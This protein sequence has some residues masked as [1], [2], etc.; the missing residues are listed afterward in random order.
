MNKLLSSLSVAVIAGAVCF[1]LC[2][3]VVVVFHGFASQGYIKSS[4][5]NQY[6]VSDSADGSFNFNDFGINFS[7]QLSPELRVG[8]QLFAQSRGNLGKDVVTVDWAYGDYRY[9]DWLGVRV[10]KVKI[11]LGLYNTSRDNDALR[12]PILLPRGGGAGGGRGRA[13]AG[14]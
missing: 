11:P 7:K 3:A 13:G 2:F 6:P 14:V 5:G 8:M 9:Q 1:S 12:N 10:G 4:N